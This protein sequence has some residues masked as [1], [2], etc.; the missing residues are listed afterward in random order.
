MLMRQCSATHGPSATRS[1]VPHLSQPCP[2]AI[3]CNSA[4]R[5][6]RIHHGDSIIWLARTPFHTTGP[7]L[8]PFKNFPS[9]NE[10]FG[11]RNKRC[12]ADVRISS[13]YFSRSWVPYLGH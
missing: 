6:G 12:N 5:C 4:T 8:T 11:R 2:H 9:P 10:D 1:H 7:T 13:M 3:S